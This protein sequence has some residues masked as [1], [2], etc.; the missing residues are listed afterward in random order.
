MSESFIDDFD[1]E[2][3][4][5]SHHFLG[6]GNLKSPIWFIGMEEGGGNTKEEISVRL[7]AWN[8]LGR[9]DVCDIVE[10]HREIEQIDYFV[11][12]PK[13]QK[14]WNKLIR[15]QLGLKLMKPTTEDVRIYQRDNLGRSNSENLLIEL[16]PLPSPG[17]NIWH[18]N[19]FSDLAYLRSRHEYF[20]YFL[21]KRVSL[22]R[23]KILKYHPKIIVFYGFSYIEHWQCTVSSKFKF[24]EDLDCYIASRDHMTYLVIRHPTSRLK[25]GYIE[26]IAGYLNLEL[27]CV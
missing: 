9:V 19:F 26:K 1:K 11:E 12:R 14:T 22:L 17:I 21:S 5:F 13:I 23:K 6:Y 8:K 4:D 2:L 18:Y 20:S 25:S 24:N 15:L 16:M 7:K 27:R 10:F 3:H